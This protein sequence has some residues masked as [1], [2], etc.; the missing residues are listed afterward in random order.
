MP[1]AGR[2]SE[3]NM[4]LDKVEA[5]DPILGYPELKLLPEGRSEQ[6]SSVTETLSSNSFPGNGRRQQ[7]V[8]DRL[9]DNRKQ[10]GG[11]Y[12][13]DAVATF[14]AGWAIQNQDT[15]VL[16]PSAGDGQIVAAAVPRLGGGGTNTAVRL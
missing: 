9:H 12:T 7:G 10:R 6:A 3:D 13:P 8:F 1:G 11:Y 2:Q 15:H 4:A 14:L 5:R 16:E